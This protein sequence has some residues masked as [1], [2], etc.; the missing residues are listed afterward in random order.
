MLVKVTM[1]AFAVVFE[2][3]VVLEVVVLEVVFEVVFFEVVVAFDVVVFEVVGSKV[4]VFEAVVFELVLFVVALFC[5]LF[6]PQLKTQLAPASQNAEVVP[7]WPDLAQHWFEGHGFREARSLYFAGRCVP[8]TWGPHTACGRAT[9]IG[10]APELRQTKSPCFN[11][12]QPGQPQDPRFQVS[13]LLVV[14]W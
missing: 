2:V 9:G 4:L 13:I 6:G 7:H 10:R 14:I 11:L 8:G 12:A 3:V 5:V 1:F